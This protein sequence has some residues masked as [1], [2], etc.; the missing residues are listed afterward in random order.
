MLNY[1]KIVTKQVSA[2]FFLISFFFDTTLCLF[3]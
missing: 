1:T 2:G 3:V